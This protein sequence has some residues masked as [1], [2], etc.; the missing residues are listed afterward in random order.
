M[1]G[2]EDK[3]TAL[4]INMGYSSGEFQMSAHKSVA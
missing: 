4:D 3:G 2:R 1:E